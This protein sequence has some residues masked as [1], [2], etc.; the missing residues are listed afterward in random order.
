[1]SALAGVVGNAAGVVVIGVAV[2]LAAFVVPRCPGF[3]RPWAE[4]FI[5][6]MMFAG[7]SAIAVTTLGTWADWLLEHV[8]DLLGGLD[9]AIPRAAL[10]LVSLF[11]MLGV[12][13]SL[14][15]APN[16]ATGMIAAALPLILG[17][18]AGGFIH[19]I[20]TVTVIP[21]QAFASSLNTWIGG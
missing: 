12:L 3:L 10:I 21:A 15:W 7:G 16:A 20:Y 17:L 14:I 11:L 18:V 9:A 1:M 8:A 13:V 2:L 5:I 19:E 6:V 4:R